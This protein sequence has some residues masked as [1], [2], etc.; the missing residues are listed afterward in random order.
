MPL[1][2][3]P[4]PEVSSEFRHQVETIVDSAKLNRQGVFWELP[5]THAQNANDV[6]RTSIGYGTAGILLS[7]LEFHRFTKDETVSEL[8]EKGLSWLKHQYS[9]K[10]FSHGFYL[11]TTGVVFAIQQIE[12]H[13]FGED[14]TSS[15]LLGRI[16]TEDLNTPQSLNLSTGISG[17][18]VGLLTCGLGSI[19]PDSLAETLFSKL[20]SSAKP[21]AEGVYWDFQQFSISAPLGF[22]SGN[23]GVEFCFAKVLQTLNITNHP[24]LRASLL[25]DRSKFDTLMRNWPDFE[26]TEQ[27]RNLDFSKTEK[28]LNSKDVSSH[29]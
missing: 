7:L 16:Q 9:S 4:L 8:L 21:S 18:L 3:L 19:L 14:L 11:G 20:L 15:S 23:A 27:L 5:K 26:A 24:L 22:A 25:H 12:N 29:V 6:F 28:I 13:L 17:T 2:S 1:S 10:P